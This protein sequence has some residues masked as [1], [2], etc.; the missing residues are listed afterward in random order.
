M[1]HIT[2][3][4][5]LLCIYIYKSICGIRYSNRAKMR[6]LTQENEYKNMAVT[7]NCKLMAKHKVNGNY[8]NGFHFTRHAS[9]HAQ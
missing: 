8:S 1:K 3:K 6:S 5:K 9:G 7:E 4:T 2:L